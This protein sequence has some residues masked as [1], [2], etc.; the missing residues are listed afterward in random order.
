MSN[1]AAPFAEALGGAA[2]SES[3]P[4]ENGKSDKQGRTYEQ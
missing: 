3:H 2:P 1:K 4:V